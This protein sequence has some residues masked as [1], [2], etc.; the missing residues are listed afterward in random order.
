MLITGYGFLRKNFGPDKKHLIIIWI[1]LK[2]IT[3]LAKRESGFL[4]AAL[5][6]I[7]MTLR[8]HFFLLCPL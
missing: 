7:M 3:S 8:L 2:T 5:I 1:Y 6:Y 4:T